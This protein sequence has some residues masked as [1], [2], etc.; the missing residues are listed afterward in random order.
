MT[1][2]ARRTSEFS[3]KRRAVLRL[4]FSQSLICWVIPGNME[5]WPECQPELDYIWRWWSL[6]I[7]RR[8][9][10]FWHRVVFT[11]KNFVF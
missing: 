2:P 9:V 4:I 7:R 1:M 6:E 11:L 3:A 8:A 10:L 5:P